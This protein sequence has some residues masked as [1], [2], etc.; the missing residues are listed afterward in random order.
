[1]AKSKNGFKKLLIGTSAGGMLLAGLA[2]PAEA[3]GTRRVIVDAALVF[4][5]SYAP[6]AAGQIH[7]G[8]YLNNTSGIV[9]GR[10]S[11]FILPTGLSN[12]WRGTMWVNSG[13]LSATLPFIIG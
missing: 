1:M 13:T 5:S 10:R 8:T 4:H 2:A 12:G 7:R 11:G 9:N 3:T 6:N